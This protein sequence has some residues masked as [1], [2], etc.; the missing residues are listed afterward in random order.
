MDAPQPAPIEAPAP[1]ASPVAAVLA[2]L[3]GLLV[4]LGS[5]LTW[6]SV[7]ADASALNGGSVTVSVKGMDGDGMI[8]LIAGIVLV[9]LGGV[10]YAMRGRNMTAISIIALLGGVVAA[11]VAIYDITTAKSTGTD[12]VANAIASQP[13]G[14]LTVDQIRQVLSLISINV[15]VEIGV[16]LVAVA[17]IVGAVGGA[18]GIHAS[19]LAATPSS[20]AVAVSPPPYT[21][22]STEPGPP[23]ESTPPATPPA[24]P[25]PGSPPP[26]APDEGTPP[27][28]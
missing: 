26:P 19:R 7:T 20:G 8:T 5:T 11:L 13:H 27:T 2:I 16:I 10:M 14:P 18:L 17:G 25:P 3:G 24:G 4:I 9:I 23:M 15:S 1:T 28:V 6:F 12:S 21:P 22:P